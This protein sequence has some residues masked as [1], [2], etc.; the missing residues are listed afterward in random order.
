MP[1]RCI[2]SIVECLQDKGIFPDAYAKSEYGSSYK[3]SI[4]LIYNENNY[5]LSKY[6][7]TDQ[8]YIID[9]K[10]IISITGYQVQT[11]S[12]GRGWMTVW[13]LSV[14]FDNKTW[15]IVDSPPTNMENR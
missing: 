3:P 11:Y 9:F 2:K 1:E 5:Y 10:Q 7:N 12:Y 8:W 15:R 14:S 6:D 13:N 4:A